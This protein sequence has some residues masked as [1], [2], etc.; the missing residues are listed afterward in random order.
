[1]AKSAPLNEVG[2]LYT[3]AVIPLSLFIQQ[4]MF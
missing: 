1:M 4:S 2:E 3:K